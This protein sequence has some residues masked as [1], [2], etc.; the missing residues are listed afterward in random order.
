MSKVDKFLQKLEIGKRYEK[1]DI[2]PLLE[3]K[4]NT[5]LQAGIITP[6]GMSL[7]ILFI[8]HNK[9]KRTTPY[10]DRIKNNKL[11]MDGEKSHKKDARLIKSI[12]NDTVI[13][14]Y[15]DNY[16]ESF[17]Y[18]GEVKL[19]RYILKEDEPS[20]FI[21]DIL[22]KEALEIKY[23]ETL[24]SEGLYEIDITRAVPCSVEKK[25]NAHKINPITPEVKSKKTY[26][27]DASIGRAVIEDSNFLCE[28]G[29]VA[30]K[31]FIA[32]TTKKEYM[33][34][35][36]LIPISEISNFWLRYNVNIDCPENIVCLCPNC[37]KQIHLGISQDKKRLLK[38]LFDKK[39]KELESIGVNISF[40]ELCNLYNID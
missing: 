37:H 35:H 14:F 21:F 19:N 29:G 34:P 18:Y 11:E 24:K 16:F 36:H 28:V 26:K 38:Q 9:E 33:E 27:R 22:K 12:N 39:Q 7:I 31:S 30:H 3:Y 10:V 25:R 32:N 1:K 5:R 20:K 2:V 8:T 17:L 6:A 15:K 13:L 40:K 4:E 23:A